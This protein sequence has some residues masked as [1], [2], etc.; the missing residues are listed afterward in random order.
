MVDQAGHVALL[1]VELP[2]GELVGRLD[3]GLRTLEPPCGERLPQRMVGQSQESSV[4]EH[5]RV[6]QGLR[7]ALGQGRRAGVRGVADQYDRPR[8]H[9]AGSTC[10]SNRV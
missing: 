10:V 1:M 7:A 5:G 3:D 8:F 9:G 6:F 4:G 2:L